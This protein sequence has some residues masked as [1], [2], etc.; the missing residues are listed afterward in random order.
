LLAEAG[1]ETDWPAAPVLENETRGD[2]AIEAKALADL[3]SRNA[4]TVLDLA[5][6]RNYLAGHIPGA[7]F[8]IRTRL[9]RALEKIAVGSTLVLTSEDGTLAAL[10]VAEAESLIDR[11]VRFLKGGNVAWQAAGQPL[12]AEAKMA[13]EAIDQLRK[14]YERSGDTKAAMR[15]YLAW[16]VDLLPRIERDGSLQFERFRPRRGAAIR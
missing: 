13:D 11:P 8:A 9:A 1:D 7:W 14:P 5:L 12:S 15:E 4:A 10:A 3:V 6:S 16:E 2:A